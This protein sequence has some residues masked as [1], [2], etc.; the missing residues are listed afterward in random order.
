MELPKKNL[1]RQVSA[2]VGELLCRDEGKRVK[3][4]S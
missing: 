3:I 2:R 4:G 1:T